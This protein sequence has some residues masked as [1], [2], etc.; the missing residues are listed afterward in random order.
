[1]LGFVGVVAAEIYGFAHFGDGVGKGFAC[2]AHG[3]HH[4]GG[5]VLFQQVGK[6]FQ[7]TCAL[8]GG[9]GGPLGLR[10]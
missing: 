8:G 6:A 4:Q 3:E 10:G 9:G 2:F 1:M 5:G 7:A